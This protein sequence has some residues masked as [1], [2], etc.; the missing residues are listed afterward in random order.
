[1]LLIQLNLAMLN[2]EGEELNQYLNDDEVLF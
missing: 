1:M 2:G